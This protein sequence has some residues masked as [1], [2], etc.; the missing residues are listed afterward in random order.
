MLHTHTFFCYHHCI[1][2]ATDSFTENNTCS[3]RVGLFINDGNKV[4][5]LG[6]VNLNV[7]TKPV[8]YFY[9]HTVHIK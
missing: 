3:E 8:S 2:V 4:F 7:V 6:T 1:I 5:V 9:V